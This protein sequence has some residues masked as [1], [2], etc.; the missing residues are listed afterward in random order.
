[1]TNDLGLL[2]SNF[3]LPNSKT[4]AGRPPWIDCERLLR[5]MQRLDLHALAGTSNVSTLA[6]DW[7]VG[8]PPPPPSTT[9]APNGTSPTGQ[10]PSVPSRQS[11]PTRRGCAQQPQRGIA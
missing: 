11:Y 5:V 7:E 8:P 2:T 4:R 10:H 1:M 6:T 9:H 3:R